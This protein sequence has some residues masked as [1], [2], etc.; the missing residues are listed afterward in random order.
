MYLKSL[1]RQSMKRKR[2]N[3]RLHQVFGINDVLCDLKY[4][5]NVQGNM[6]RGY[7]VGI[8]MNPKYI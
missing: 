6:S 1:G 3:E 4:K 2:K 5:N 8:T 7:G